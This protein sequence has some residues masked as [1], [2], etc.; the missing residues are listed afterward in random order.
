VLPDA[1][2]GHGHR[3]AGRLDAARPPDVTR[4]GLVLPDELPPDEEGSRED[5]EHDRD[6]GIDPQPEEVMGRVDAQQFLECPPNV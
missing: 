3:G 2:L 6:P 1:A 4:F 5:E